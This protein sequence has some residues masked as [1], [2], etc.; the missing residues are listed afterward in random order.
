M[1]EEIEHTKNLFV[2]TH[3][4]HECCD[5]GMTYVAHEST[6]GTPTEEIDWETRYPNAADY[7]LCLSCGITK[8]SRKYKDWFGEDDLDVEVYTHI[9]ENG[10]P[11]KVMYNN[12]MAC[13]IYSDSVVVFGYDGNEYCHAFGFASKSLEVPAL[14]LSIENKIVLND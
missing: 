3:P 13:L 5:K 9:E 4:V 11:L 6:W 14:N 12:Y 1:Q 7:W 2:S 10:Q 8:V